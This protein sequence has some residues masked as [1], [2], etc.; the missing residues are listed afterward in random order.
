M[1][2]KLS[3]TFVPRVYP[4][5]DQLQPAVRPTV[6][7]HQRGQVQGRCLLCRT[8]TGKYFLKIFY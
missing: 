4:S 5:L 1:T 8:W 7:L 6:A 2:G 3:P